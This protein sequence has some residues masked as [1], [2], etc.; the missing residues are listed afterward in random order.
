MVRRKACQKFST[1]SV[2]KPALVALSLR[3]RG[4]ENVPF[5]EKR[6]FLQRN[7]FI[8]A[9]VF[10]AS[11]RCGTRA[12]E[13]VIMG[14]RGK[15]AGETIGLSKMSTTNL[16]HFVN[17]TIH[18]IVLA[19]RQSFSAN[20]KAGI[21]AYFKARSIP[22]DRNAFDAAYNYYFAEGGKKFSNIRHPMDL[23]DFE[24]EYLYARKDFRGLDQI[25]A[26]EVNALFSKVVGRT[27]LTPNQR[28]VVKKWL[29]A[30]RQELKKT[31]T[32]LLEEYKRKPGG[33][34][35]LFQQPQ[36]SPAWTEFFN[37]LIQI[38]NQFIELA[39]QQALAPFLA[40]PRVKQ[41][42]ATR[43]LTEATRKLGTRAERM[44]EYAPHEKEKRAR[45]AEVKSR[46]QLASI[47]GRPFD[48]TEYALTAMTKENL[49]TGSMFR[50]LVKK[51]QLKRG[52]IVNLF[53]S[54]SL[55]QKIFLQTMQE[56]DFVQRFGVKHID[57]L[58]R[59]LAYIGPTGR[60]IQRTIRNF[61]SP[62][63]REMFEFLERN[64]LIETHH[65]GGKV[66]Y[67]RRG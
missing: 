17:Q 12:A 52:T 62:Q 26:E 57:T 49:Q 58:A 46:N 53:T 15:T 13:K 22:F 35:Q 30:H 41:K 19:E 14:T 37:R 5:E 44:A 10:A 8:A 48:S 59:A 40:R 18:E 6:A 3:D 61:Q 1:V 9:K 50:E 67:L 27:R 25:N 23:A 38:N 29:S 31:R 51:G 36:D 43:E 16:D 39:R 11:A 2:S 24:R 47:S 63:G 66:V 60:D 34:K 28:R 21:Q 54:G 64:G 20:L 45:T 4:I 56:T 65:G 32:Q 42:P 55:T 7:L 33:L